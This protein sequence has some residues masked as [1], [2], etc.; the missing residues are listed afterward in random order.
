MTSV[1]LLDIDGVLVKPGGYRAAVRASVNYFFNLMGLPHFEIPEEKITWLESRGITSEWD[2]VPLLIATLWEDILSRHPLPSLPSD[3]SSAAIQ[4]GKHLNRYEPIELHIPEFELVAGQCPADTALK[5][6]LFS[7]IPR[8]LRT[9]LLHGS[10]DVHFSKT[11]RTFQHFTLGSEGFTQTYNLPAEIESESFLYKYDRS[12]ID[13]AIRDKLLQ[14]GIHLAAFTARPSAPP[15]EVKAPPLGYSPEAEIALDLVGLPDIPLISF[16]K[17][18]FL[19]E[20]RGYDP[21]IL[22]KPSPVQALAGIAAALTGDEWSSLQASCDWYETGQLTGAL[23]D[24]PKSFEVSVVE[25]TLG[26]V[27][28]VWAA[29]EIL[30]EIGLDVTV[31]AY[32]LTS[33][34]AAKSAAF[35]AAGVPYFGDW[36]TLIDM[37][38]P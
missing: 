15:R 20:Q 37:F 33:G 38:N 25:D 1:L 12:N 30:R 22:L 6:G 35:E 27:R 7:S 3:V 16:G 2:M 23:V 13:D 19:G 28:S 36:D 24:L 31:R 18:Q 21:E 29:G 4:I 14:P 9:N 26:G 11:L 32:G 10:R 8:G 34:S 5:S 17:L